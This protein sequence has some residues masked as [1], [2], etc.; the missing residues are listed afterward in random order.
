MSKTEKPLNNLIIAETWQC[1]A[2]L[3]SHLLSARV[4]TS[5]AVGFLLFGINKITPQ[6]LFPGKPSHDQGYRRGEDVSSARWI[7]KPMW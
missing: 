4:F 5:L 3:S 6:F 7:N 2:H 1:P